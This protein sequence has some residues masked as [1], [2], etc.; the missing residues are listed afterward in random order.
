MRKAAIK[1][2]KISRTQKIIFGVLSVFLLIAL[3]MQFNYFADLFAKFLNWLFKPKKPI[4]PDDVKSI[5]LS[6]LT[7]GVGTFL[8]TTGTALLAVFPPVGAIIIVVG[9]VVAGA[10]LYNLAN[11]LG[12]L[13]S[14]K[15]PKAK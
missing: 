12:F 5:A 15:L 4:Q 3:L 13:D 2:V 1:N 14:M 10:S 11:K 7:V 9:L 6:L 8:V